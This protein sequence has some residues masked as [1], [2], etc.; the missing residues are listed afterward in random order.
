MKRVP[1]RTIQLLTGH[2]DLRTTMRYSHLEPSAMTETIS[3][4]GAPAG[5]G[6]GQQAV[7]GAIAALKVDVEG[8]ELLR[9]TKRKSQTIV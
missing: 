1:P 6:F 7:N 3:L 4:L 8:L 5:D 9:S 2:S